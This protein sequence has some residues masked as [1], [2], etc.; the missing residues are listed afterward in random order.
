M[1]KTSSR[2]EPSEKDNIL[3]STELE[4][5]ELFDQIDYIMINPRIKSGTKIECET[6]Q[7]KIFVVKK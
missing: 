6:S 5:R 1:E 7:S 4:L 3:I 2:I